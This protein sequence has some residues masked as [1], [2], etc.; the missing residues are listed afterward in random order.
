[1]SSDGEKEPGQKAKS[2]SRGGRHPMREAA[3]AGHGHAFGMVKAQQLK[4]KSLK[5]LAG[6]GGICI[7]IYL[8]RGK[9]T[10]K[11][12]MVGWHHRLNGHGSE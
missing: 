9:G 12:E 6:R 3:W 5:E 7:C 11:D 8:F 10:T 2:S 1:M 4:K